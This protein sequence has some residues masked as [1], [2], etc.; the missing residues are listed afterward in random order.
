MK[1]F[2]LALALLALTPAVAEAK[3]FSVSLSGSARKDVSVSSPYQNPSATYCQ[4]S[5]T[6]RTTGYASA[7]IAARPL[8][9]GSTF[10]GGNL[11]FVVRLSNLKAGGREEVIGDFTPRPEAGP[12]HESECT[13]PSRGPFVQTCRQ[14][15]NDAVSRSGSPF[16]MSS[17]RGRM[18]VRFFPDSSFAI[19][20]EGDSLGGVWM[21]KA[22]PTSLRLVTL[23][24]MPRGA[25]VLRAGV[26]FYKNDPSREINNL[27]VVTKLTYTLRVRRVT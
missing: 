8:R 27:T 25:T 6:T 9:N 24:T 14:F 4:G 20:C 10:S 5:A 15:T 21:I 18:G 11:D 17:V 3:S 26:A 2:T 13:I 12:G 7:T 22:V 19:N 16:R 23:N 1:G